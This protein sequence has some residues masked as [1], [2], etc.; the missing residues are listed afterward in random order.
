[1][2]NTIRDIDTTTPAV[3]FRANTPCSLA[4]VRSLGRMGVPVTCVDPKPRSLAKRSRYCTHPVEWDFDNK[5]DDE[6]IQF[7]L[8][9]AARHDT[10]PVLV[11]TFDE[12]NL[13]VDRFRAALSAGYRLPQSRPG[14]V[15]RL[16]SK[17]TMYE[18]C[19]ENGVPTP[20]TLFPETPV[21]AMRGVSA[22][23][24]PI[25][26]KGIDA[27]RLLEYTGG[28]R[29]TKVERPEEFE[30]AYRTFDEP[31]FPNLAVQEFVEGG[32]LDSTIMAGYFD[33]DGRC[34]FGMTGRKLRELPITGGI[35]ALVETMP[36]EAMIDSVT[37]LVA[38]TGFRGLVDTDFRYD[39]NTGEYKLLD[40]NPRLGANFRAFVDDNGL[41][42]VR[43]LYLD[44]TGQA[45][46]SVESGSGRRWL[47]EEVDVI[48]SVKLMRKGSL[49][50][51]AWRQSLR[52]VAELTFL[53]R[54]DPIPG[55]ALVGRLFGRLFA[56][57]RNR[58]APRAATG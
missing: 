17:R 42:S 47:N 3:V 6:T 46:P 5:S 34:L 21:E 22:L 31:G 52:G 9:I 32:P 18:L 30:S 36:G 56:G 40:F 39:A 53:D 55:V 58:L 20:R 24:F 14:A 10:K 19:L 13:F 57:I 23:R 35:S 26:I 12:N 54:G 49:D 48:A 33:S 43:A 2:T 51:A 37:R 29:L 38:A 44:L 16:Y 41:D 27:D 25:V 1:M 7:L 50:V 15:G 4:I 11:A 8:E 45:V 28:L